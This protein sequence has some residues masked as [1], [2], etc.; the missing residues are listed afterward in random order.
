MIKAQVLVILYVI[1]VC[2]VGY[3][4]L[5]MV[6]WDLLVRGAHSACTQREPVMVTA[7][8]AGAKQWQSHAG[9]YGLEPAGRHVID[10]STVQED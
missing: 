6:A 1:A 5:L 8:S 3:R 2:A 9:M 4:L 7:A 10:V